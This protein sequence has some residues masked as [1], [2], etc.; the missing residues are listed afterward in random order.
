MRSYKSQ[1]FRSAISV[2]SISFLHTIHNLIG[3]IL[4]SVVALTNR[5]CV[6]KLSAS[7]LSVV[8][9][10]CCRYCCCCCCCTNQ[11]QN[12][13]IWNNGLSDSFHIFVRCVAVRWFPNKTKFVK[14]FW[15]NP[16]ILRTEHTL[17]TLRL[18]RWMVRRT[19]CFW[20]II[21]KAHCFGNRSQSIYFAL[22][23]ALLLAVALFTFV[24][25][26]FYPGKWFHHRQRSIH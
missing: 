13:Q 20:H 24:H 14:M 3:T 15:P 7:A 25:S 9:A 26:Y 11:L 1:I 6:H 10:I 12:V 8:S 23:L 21:S 16:E 22:T 17:D 19:T 2:W 18:H 5:R 4:V